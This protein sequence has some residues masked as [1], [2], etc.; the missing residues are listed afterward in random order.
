[1]NT[2]IFL[3]QKTTYQP[4]ES[5]SL[6]RDP[7]PPV[8][9]RSSPRILRVK[10][11]SRVAETP[12]VKSPEKETTT[13]KSVIVKDTVSR[14]TTPPPAPIFNT[15]T[16]SSSRSIPPSTTTTTTK[17]LPKRDDDDDSFIEETRTTTTIIKPLEIPA[18]PA[19]V[20]TVPQ[21][22]TTTT[23]VPVVVPAAETMT[24]REKPIYRTR[25]R[26]RRRTRTLS[27]S[28]ISDYTT[29]ST[30]SY[31][32]NSTV[33]PQPHFIKY[34]Q[35]LPPRPPIQ[36]TIIN[37]PPTTIAPERRFIHKAR[38]IRTHSGYYSSDLDFGKQKVYKSDYK[39]RHYY[40]CNWCKGRCDL[41][42]SSC[43]CCEWFYGCPLWGL[44][45]LGL[46][47]LALIIAFFTLLG[48]QPTINSARRSETAI[49][50]VLNRTQIIYGFLKNCGTSSNTPTTLPL[51]ANTAG[52][53]TSRVILSSYYTVSKSVKISFHNKSCKVFF[54]IFIFLHKFL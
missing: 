7:S 42:N 19:V 43:S 26:R 14:G 20:T 3:F 6:I 13:T 30:S 29:S 51:C 11:V 40:Y 2:H 17:V 44:I 9:T 8:M 21:V 45:L 33:T 25:R 23:T 54:F 22:A 28:T 47:L 27:P 16:T 53:T 36:T 52:T 10:R 15:F 38:R 50:Q 39:Y 46:L 48:L 5:S 49:T 4:F 1:M 37:D 24:V 32:T 34:P 35:I 41:P 18:A 12:P 31:T